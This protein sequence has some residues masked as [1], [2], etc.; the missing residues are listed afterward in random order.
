MGYGHIRKFIKEYAPRKEISSCSSSS[1]NHQHQQTAADGASTATKQSNRCLLIVSTTSGFG[2]AA[3]LGPK[4]ANHLSRS[5]E[6]VTVIPTQH[7]G[8]VY[9]I[10]ANEQENLADYQIA[11]ILGGDGAFSEA[12]N[13]MLNRTDGQT[14]TLAHCPGGSGCST[15][16]NT[17]GVWRGTDVAKACDIICQGKVGKM[18]VIK[19]QF[20]GKETANYSI[21]VV[22]GGLY[23][24]IVDLAD[25]YYRWTYHIMGPTARYAFG[26]IHALIKYGKRD[27][28]RLVRYTITTKD[29][30]DEVVEVPTHGFGIY[31]DGRVMEHARYTE[32][33]L[34]CGTMSVAIDKQYL[35]LVDH[36][37]YCGDLAKEKKLEGDVAENRFVR[38][39]VISVRAEPLKAKESAGTNDQLPRPLT[40]FMDGEKGR[41]NSDWMVGPYSTT[42]LPGK[43]DVIIA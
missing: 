25:R 14:I 33:T 1:Q 6:S 22:S 35:G 12:V 29:G 27:N 17:I 32:A 23:T 39:D 38:N 13:G 9:E 11:V 41:G 43:L 4:V 8:H 20:P 15:S 30:R 5:F 10:V 40:V 31:N 42:V 34:G 2:N 24:D 36:L 18:D 28:D 19:V 16:G 3:K 37:K 7:A 21:S 26:M